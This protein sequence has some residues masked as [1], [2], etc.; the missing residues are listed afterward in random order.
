MGW[1]CGEKIRR[2]GCTV[3]G[4]GVYHGL[5]NHAR[6]IVILMRYYSHD[7]TYGHRFIVE[8]TVEDSVYAIGRTADATSAATSTAIKGG[9]K[10][11]N[12]LTILNVVKMLRFG[13]E[14]A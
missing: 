11:R 13:Q 5:G 8:D 3:C 14:T 10:D 12:V 9:R 4:G 2:C 1:R 6:L 7:V